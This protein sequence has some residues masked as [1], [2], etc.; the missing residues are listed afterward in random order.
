MQDHT[1][2]SCDMRQLHVLTQCQCCAFVFAAVA[3]PPPPLVLLQT[4]WH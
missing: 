1:R 3:P 4:P 2:V